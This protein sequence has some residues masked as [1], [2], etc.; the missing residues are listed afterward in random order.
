MSN[1]S[2]KGLFSSKSNLALMAFLAIAGVFLVAEH[3]VHVIE[4]LPFLLLAACLLMHLFHGHGGH[5][6]HGDQ[7]K[8][9]QRKDHDH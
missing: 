1:D 2:G 6:G 8:G 4:W 5:G 7:G 9:A 3:R